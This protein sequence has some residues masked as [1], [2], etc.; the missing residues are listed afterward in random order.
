MNT[1]LKVTTALL[2]SLFLVSIIAVSTP[3]I[4]AKPDSRL[5]INIMAKGDDLDVGLDLGIYRATT[6][7]V[8]KIRFDKDSGVL[9]GRVEF[10]MKIYEISSGEKVYAIKGKLKE[11]MMVLPGQ[12]FDCTV[13]NVLWTNLWFVFGMGMIKTTDTPLEIVHRGISILL[14]NTGGKWIPAGVVMM[15]SPYGEY[16]GGFWEDGGWA[17]A[18]EMDMV[19]MVPIF[20][21]VTYLTNYM[22]KFVP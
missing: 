19:N 7:I 14:P 21:G 13:R 17:F 9:Q 1:K 10:H 3:A 16:E 6:L 22:E 4:A 11:S 20:G 12:E 15:V 8:G 5:M 2:T 18:G